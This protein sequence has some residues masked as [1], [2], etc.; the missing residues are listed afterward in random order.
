M[1]S[2]NKKRVISNSNN[3]E[4]QRY[5][6]NIFKKIFSKNNDK[7]TSL[8]KFKKNSKMSNIKKINSVEIL[9]LEG[10]YINEYGK[11]EEGTYLKL[12]EENENMVQSENG[13]IIFRKINYYSNS[14]KYIINTY[15]SSWLQGY[16]NLKIMP[17]SEKTALVKWPK[18]E[19]FIPHLHWGGEEILVINGTFIDEYGTYEKGTWIRSPHQSKHH[20][21]VKEETII[22]VKTGHLIN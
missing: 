21:Y 17:L 19:H 18:D 15:S 10:T 2:D 7:E 4:W 11:F 3:I 6:N 1:N 12:H 22:F 8:I 9:I 14:D 16:G 13:C 5:N 20:P